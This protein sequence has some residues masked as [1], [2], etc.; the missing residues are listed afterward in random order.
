MGPEPCQRYIAKGQEVMVTVLQQRKLQ[1]QHREGC[2][3]GGC[4]ERLENHC[5][6]RF[7]ELGW[8]RPWAACSSLEE[9]PRVCPGD[10]TKI[11]F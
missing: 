10:W 8:R 7:S 3:I 11:Q 5:L 9:V 1:L 4:L 2:F 6:Q